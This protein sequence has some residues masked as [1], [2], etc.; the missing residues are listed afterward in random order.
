MEVDT[1]GKIICPYNSECGCWTPECH[2]CGWNPKVERARKTALLGGTSYRVPFTGYCNVIAN[3]PEEAIERA[4]Q[5][6][7]NDAHHI[8]GEPESKGGE[9]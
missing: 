6:N 2:K 5:S 4:V 9:E 3:S 1:N 8:F 7:M